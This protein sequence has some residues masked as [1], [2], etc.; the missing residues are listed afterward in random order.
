MSNI[1][2]HKCLEDV[3]SPSFERRKATFL[4]EAHHYEILAVLTSDS[5]E[6]QLF[7]RVQMK[8]S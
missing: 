2:G 7:F 5:K 8:V 3:I 1:W 4:W 6:K